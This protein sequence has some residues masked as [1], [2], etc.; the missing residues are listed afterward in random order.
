VSFRSTSEFT[1]NPTMSSSASS[2]RPETTVP[3]GMSVPQPSR[4]SS[5]ATAACATMNSVASC[6]RAR[7]TRAAW[8]A[9]SMVRSTRPAR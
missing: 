3:N 6:P 7:S 4:V 2:V 8:V 5:A 9:A 1:K